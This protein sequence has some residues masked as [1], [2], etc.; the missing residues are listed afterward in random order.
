MSLPEII[1]W[2]LAFA[3]VTAIIYGWG[4]A[5]SRN[6]QRDLLAALYSKGEALVKKLLKKSGSL[7]RSELEKALSGIRASLFYSPG[8][9]AIVQD[10]KVFTSELLRMMA[11]KNL[12][13]ED[14]NRFK[15]K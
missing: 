15:L 2:V 6:R 9:R 8:Q 3:V 4:L 1:L 7:P 10:P 12:I 13:V 14:G 5:K 11:E